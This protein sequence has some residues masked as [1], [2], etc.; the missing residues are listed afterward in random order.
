MR[1]EGQ[2]TPEAARADDGTRHVVGERRK[3]RVLEHKVL[4]FQLHGFRTAGQG[5]AGV[6]H[7]CLSAKHAEGTLGLEEFGNGGGCGLAEATKSSGEARQKK[8][9][10]TS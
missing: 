3:N 10:A 5:L 7:G 1:H 4:V 2:L 8:R 6:Q 9:R